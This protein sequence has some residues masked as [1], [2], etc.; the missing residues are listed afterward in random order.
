MVKVAPFPGPNPH[1]MSAPCRP[2]AR[3]SLRAFR[4]PLR[5][6]KAQETQR[7]GT[8]RAP[9]LSPRVR[10]ALTSHPSNTRVERHVGRYQCMY[11]TCEYSCMA[12]RHPAARSAA[13]KNCRG[14]EILGK[15]EWRGRETGKEI[16]HS[17][18]KK[19]WPGPSSRG[20]AGYRLSCACSSLPA[21][22]LR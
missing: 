2:R 3:H 17:P 6:A 12:D 1:P 4:T 15:F 11:V 14:R 5:T 19:F 8:A 7:G 10:S 22:S 18:Q 21:R 16:A 9:P 13:G 20:R